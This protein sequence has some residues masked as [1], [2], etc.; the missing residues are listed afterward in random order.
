MNDL[1][2]SVT[3]AKE[4]TM[5]YDTD[6]LILGAGPV[7]KTLA[8]ELTRHGVKPR[9]VDTA[10]GIREV[11]KAMIVHVRTQEM[12]DKV[13]IADRLLAEAQPLTEVVVQAYGKHVG[14]WDLDDIDSP[15]KHPLIIGQNRTQHLLLDLLQSRG[16]AVGWNTEGVS[17]EMTPD[18]V[19]TKLKHTDPSTHAVT[20]E[21][22]RSHYIVGCDGANSIVR[23]SLD[24]TFEGERY[25]GEQFIQAD[26]RIKWHCPRA[27]PTCS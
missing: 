17:F 8:N 1:A 9:I 26:C 2:P 13:G 18:G 21:T 12:L 20:E 11:S 16:V 7:G 5:N 15:Y 27:A 4:S 22:V 10:P 23:R 14:A 25:S 3:Q 6:V 19:T 24:F